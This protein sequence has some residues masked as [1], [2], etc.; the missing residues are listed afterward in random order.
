[1]ASP[2]PLRP[3]EKDEQQP[4]DTRFKMNVEKHEGLGNTNTDDVS[5]RKRERIK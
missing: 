5:A 4:F 2:A 3:I 1:M